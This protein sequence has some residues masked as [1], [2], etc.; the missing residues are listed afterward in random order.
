MGK[1]AWLGSNSKGLD[2]MNRINESGIGFIKWEEFRQLSGVL[3]NRFFS[4]LF[5][6]RQ[7]NM[8]EM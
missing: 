7:E 2:K 1:G 5:Q 3:K 6:V 4:N 8:A